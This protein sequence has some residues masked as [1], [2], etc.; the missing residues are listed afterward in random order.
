[1]ASLFIPTLCPQDKAVVFALL[2]TCFELALNLCCR[3]NLYQQANPVSK[4]LLE[5]VYVLSLAPFNGRDYF[6][7]LHSL[8]P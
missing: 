8:E 5:T 3:N 6:W 4:G 1:M 7:S 2:R